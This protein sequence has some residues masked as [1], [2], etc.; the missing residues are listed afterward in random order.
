MPAY[1]SFILFAEMRTGS[2]FL[3][4]NLNA[5]DGV[6]CLGEVF[7]PGFIGYPNRDDCLGV[8]R[9]ARDADPLALLERIRSAPG[10]NG[11]RFFH[12]HDPRA[13]DAALDDPRVAK[14]ILT[15]NPVDS[16]V[17]LKIARSTDQWKLTDVRRRRPARAEFDAAEF[18][19]MLATLQ[20][21][22]LK[23]LHRLQTSGQTAFHL[24][25]EDLKDLD[26]I[27]GLAAFLGLEARLKQLDQSLKIQNPEALDK[28]VSNFAEMEQALARLDRFD[29][30]R[31]PNF[32]PRRGPQVPGF[33]A[34]AKVPL[35]HMPVRGGPEAQVEAWLAAAEGSSG[36]LERDFKQKTLRQWK[37]ARPGHRSFAVLRHPAARAH[38]VFC[39]RILLEG[40]GCFVDIRKKL[41]QRFK[42]PLPDRKAT[43][44]TVEQHRT[45]F[46]AFLDFLAANL[47]GQT[48]IRVDP[49]WATQSAL[50]EGMAQ[51]ALPDQL[52][53]EDEM[54]DAL[55]ALAASVGLEEAP[56]PARAPEDAPFP[57]ARIHDA[58]VEAKVADVYQRD[59]MT[60]G[61][62]PWRPDGPRQA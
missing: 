23:V 33:V 34:G 9:E 14:I 41:Q 20:D 12:D 58:E 25:Y 17:S 2:N 6:A 4:A 53:R 30:G 29:L 7:N 24:A 37:R 43:D 48:P 57:L 61:F 42:M 62:A 13:C 40:P 59:Y 18:Q 45:A 11:F 1:D 8:S 39:E 36:A 15:R 10:M 26:V 50:I 49:H 3:E 28:K 31:T 16:Y 52:I 22:Q 5:L 55:P 56:L 35:L 44:W 54:Q 46:L 47:N 60:F 32:E 27:N 38:A 51:F 21:F 19:Q